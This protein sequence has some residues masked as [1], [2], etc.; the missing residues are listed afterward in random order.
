MVTITEYRGPASEDFTNVNALNTAFLQMTSDLPRQKLQRLAAAPFL[1]FSFREDDDEWWHSVLGDDPQQDLIAAA[2][3]A[4]S[5]VRKLQTAGLGFLWQ[6][7]RRN[8][9]AARIISGA[10]V[11]WCEKLS[12]QTLVF[13]LDRVAARG[14]LMISRLEN[15]EGIWS[16]LL[17]NG[18]CAERSVRRSSQLS[19]LQTMLTC[20]RSVQYER[21]PAAACSM[22]AP[23]RQVADRMQVRRRQKKV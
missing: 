13:L 19:A 12:S 8:P 21:L 1:L 7:A 3:S 4:S 18:T 23:N 16:R 5:E 15:H 2:N 10:S 22:P 9:Y 14:D 11:T 6:L 20:T 17:G